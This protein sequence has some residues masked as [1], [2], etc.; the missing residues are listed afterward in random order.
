MSDLSPVDRAQ[1][2]ALMVDLSDRDAIGAEAFELA[3]EVT[4]QT[5]APWADT[6]PQAAEHWLLVHGASPTAA[7]AN[8][9]EFELS[10]RA[11]VG[12]ANGYP[13]Q[14]FAE[15]AAWLG[16]INGEDQ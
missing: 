12:I 4:A 7:A 14:D 9:P 11:L 8:A 10:M 13:V 3:V 6:D 5:P 15:I 2:L 16:E 1:F